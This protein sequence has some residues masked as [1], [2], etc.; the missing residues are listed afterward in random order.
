MKTTAWL[1]SCCLLTVPFACTIKEA[2]DKPASS[3]KGGS[4]GD[5]GA[6]G[7]AGTSSQAGG[8]SS[9]CGDVT[10]D[11]KC[12][13]SEVVYCN[14]SEITRVDCAPVGAECVT[15][16]GQA[17]CEVPS[18]TASCG[19]LTALGTCDG[20]LLKYCN[21]SAVVVATPA[22]IDCAAYGQTCDPDAGGDGGAQCVP[23][24]ACPADLTE[25]GT[26][27][28]N[29][30]HFCD[31]ANE[32][33]FDCGTD[34]CRI[35]GGFADCF[36]PSSVT[37]CGT[38]T[39][40]GRCDGSVAV[41][42]QSDLVCREDCAALGLTCVE[43]SPT[44]CQATTCPSSCATG[45]ACTNGRCTPTGT[46]SRQW[47][48]LV[49]MVGDNNLSDAAWADINEMEEVGS[50]DQVQVAVQWELSSQYT[51]VA[52]KAYRGSVYRTPIVKDTDPNLDLFM[53]YQIRKSELTIVPKNNRQ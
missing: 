33:V 8:G 41:K 14:G 36:M 5:G 6:G 43:G 35:V 51:S 27:K 13:K 53:I 32:Y 38:E 10:E 48:V 4:A 42:C 16:G 18:R 30:L 20:A 44:S 50:T 26:C 2:D 7:E 9:P 39:V 17:Q 12:E 19:T 31:T 11:G 46:P 25:N 29:V 24:G 15:T 40:A 22:Q 21:S 1:F 28:G 45:Y 52:S 23:T 37:G 47:T 49:Y 3:G 34:E